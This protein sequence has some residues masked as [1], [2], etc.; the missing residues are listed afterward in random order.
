MFPR[1]IFDL[2]SKDHDCHIYSEI[3][4]QI[5]TS[6]IE[7]QY[8]FIGQRA[9]HPRLIVSI[10]IYAYSRGVFSS[11]QIEQRCHEDL[12]FMYVA[13]MNCPN[14]RVLSDFRKDHHQFFKDCFKQTVQM[15]I[16]LKLASLGHISLDGS[17]FK[18]NSSKHKAMS[19]KNLKK[20]EEEL[21][22]EINTLIEKAAKCDREED[23]AYQERTGYEIPED[24]KHKQSRLK[25]IKK[26]KEALE[27]R[28]E[29][30]HP[31]KPIDNKKQISF[32]DEDACIMKNKGDF[33][34]CYN[35]QVSVDADNQIIVGEHVSQKGNDKQEL[36]PALEE[37]KQTTGTLPKKASMDNGYLS[38]DNLEA[39][40]DSQIDAYIA[41]NKSDRKNKEALS[42]SGR[43]VEK[44]D[45]DY[46]EADNTFICPHGQVLEM[47]REDKNGRR[48]Y[49]ADAEKCS[50]C[51]FK[52]RC[53]RSKKGEARTLTSDKNE[54]L[55]QQMTEKMERAESKEI[56]HK[57]KV[58]V[59]PV[60]GQIK[61][62]GFR[63][64]S[65]RGKDKVAGE[66]SLVCAV[67]NIKK[68]VRA[69]IKGV[70]CPENGKWVAKAAI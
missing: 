21:T 51:P 49:Q 18:A 31:D 47:K 20:Q 53:S 68:I 4:K 55:R 28:E 5:D 58:I 26:A 7:R 19:Y 27:A 70:V 11:R 48:L 61:N 67:H 69:V 43:W 13:Q 44:S 17:K 65:V 33:D 30:L 6:E 25:K 66:F 60:F 50:D 9:Y 24:L 37:V 40:E 46:I 14:F 32:A 22:N 45:F 12:S 52:T 34:Y 64:F 56:Y 39:I 8:S 29:A 16:E 54:A 38:G 10:L 2:L 41:T 57:R 36:K 15:A 3:F 63:G 1:N 23:Q 42:E 35:P 62:M 59:E